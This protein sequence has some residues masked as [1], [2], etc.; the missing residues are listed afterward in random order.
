MSNSERH[1]AAVLTGPFSELVSMEGLPLKGPIS[2]DELIIRRDAGILHRPG[3]GGEILEVGNFDQLRQRWPTARVEEVPAGLCAFPGMTDAHTHLLW[4]GKRSADFAARLSGTSYR[5]IASAGGGIMSTVRSVRNADSWHLAENLRHRAHQHLRRG[6]T[7]AEVKSGYGLD[8]ENE[9]KMLEVISDVPGGQRVSGGPGL[10]DLVPTCLAAHKNPGDLGLNNRRYLEMILGQLLP[11]IRRKNLSRRIDIFVEEGAFS[12][13]EARDYLQAAKAMG[14]SLTVHADQF[15]AGGAEL[16]V[17]LG[18]VSADHLEHS[19]DAAIAA[20]CT[21]ETAAVALP[22]ASIG[23][24]EPFAPAR[25]LLDGGASLVIASDW[26]PGSAPNGNLLLQAAILG[27][28]E[29]LS[30][31]ELWAGITFRA[32]AALELDDLGILAGGSRADFIAFE[33]EWRDPLWFQGSLPPA[34]IWK[35]GNRVV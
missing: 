5:E 17:E 6:V 4:A 24:G 25:R 34:M 30:M 10:P 9:I 23:L 2:D 1:D 33:G 20:L 16:A 13:E 32:A 11:E 19:D 28:Y 18:A 26:N 29:K 12:P 7:T 8:T 14:F 22:G 15:S 27:T 31:A 3:T 21:S 35:G